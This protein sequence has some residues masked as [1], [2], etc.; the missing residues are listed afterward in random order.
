MSVK[1]VYSCI[2]GQAVLE[3]IMMKNGN[4]YAIAV[5]KPDKEIIVD[6]QPCASMAEKYPVLGWPIIRGVFAFVDSLSVGMS[7]IQYSASLVEDD[8]Y[9]EPSGFEKWL[10][11]KFGDKTEKVI[12]GFATVLALIFAVLVFMLVPMLISSLLKR[13]IDSHFV[14]ALI[15]GVLRIVFFVLYIKAISHMEDIRRTFM[16]HGAEHK[17]INC[18]ELGKELTVEN[19]MSSSKEHKRCGTSFIVIVMIIS[20]LF[21]MLIRT[22]TVWMRVISRILLIPVIAGVSYEFLR[23]AGRS[24]SGLVNILSRPGMWMQ[25]L[26]TMEPQA[27]MAEVAIR[28]T[29]AVF[30][31]RAFL[32]REFPELYPDGIPYPEPEPEAEA[33]PQPKQEPQSEPETETEKSDREETETVT[34]GAA[35]SQTVQGGTAQAD[36]EAAGA[37]AE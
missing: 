16:Y 11:E 29:E 24:E 12:M 34:G 25:G 22:D 21:F 14:L 23:L 31:W 9:D 32:T 26:T 27:D 33:D 13:W 3:G 30:D 36:T 18:V 6:V 20:I 4:K 37:K 8:E 35:A 10:Y 5:R 19:V 2:G 15:E 28:A 17:C 1:R 7:T